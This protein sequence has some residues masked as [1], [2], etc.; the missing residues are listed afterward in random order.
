MSRVLRVPPKTTRITSAATASTNA[1]A[2]KAPAMKY[3]KKLPSERPAAVNARNPKTPD[4]ASIRKGVVPLVRTFSA[5]LK[6]FSRSANFSSPSSSTVST[7][8]PAFSAAESRRRFSKVERSFFCSNTWIKLGD[9]GFALTATRE[10]LAAMATTAT[11][12]AM[13]QVMP[14]KSLCCAVFALL[15]GRTPRAEGPGGAMKAWQSPLMQASTAPVAKHVGRTV[16]R[17][18]A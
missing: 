2:P 18:M 14:T 12:V 3:C 1:G 9:P 13:P 8:T 16:R 4:P 10:D 5:K 6:R 17:V 15:M 11:L 7:L